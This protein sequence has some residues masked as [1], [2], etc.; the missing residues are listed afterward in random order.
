VTA[1]LPPTERPD[2]SDGDTP[3][4]IRSRSSRAD[5]IFHRGATGIGA[6]VLAVFGS[7]GVFLG[8]QA[9]PTL[10]RYGLHFFT[11]H[12]WLP[13]RDLIGISAVILGTF[14]VAI[15]ALTFSFP[16]AVTTA[17]YISEYAPARLKG[18]LVAT[19]DLMASVPSIVYGIWG[20]FLM[21]PGIMPISHWIHQ[22]FGWLPFF[23]VD[24][25][26]DA[27][28]WA[29]SKYYGSMFIAGIAVSM[30]V[31]PI[32][33]S[34]MREVFSQAPPGEREAALALGSTRW[35]MIRAV[36]LPFGRGGIVGGTMLA[37]GRALGET[38]AV[39]LILAPNFEIKVRVLENGGNTV[40]ALIASRFGEATGA[41]L[42]A[43]LT[44]GFL[45]FVITVLVNTFAAVIV[46]RSRSGAAT[47][48]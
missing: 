2:R 27:P 7:V 22:N 19:V 32:A 44:A 1:V 18:L 23:A 41:Q 16:L 17:L 43:L 34:V 47:E 37:L 26:A 25:D 9:V 8:L 5:R 15:V 29:Q 30:M 48:I 33:C 45:L 28:I 4:R 20:F 21:E 10:R 13:E 14:L 46:N 38:V 36:V 12:E 11:E 40:S 3:R 6:L 35:G 31:I 42:A 24:T 39:L